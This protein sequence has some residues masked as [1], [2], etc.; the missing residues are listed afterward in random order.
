MEEKIWSGKGRL[1]QER[2]DEQRHE[3]L[4]GQIARKDCLLHINGKVTPSHGDKQ[5]K[6]HID[7]KD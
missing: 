4:S 7:L 2:G 6:C 1:E 5:A 3:V